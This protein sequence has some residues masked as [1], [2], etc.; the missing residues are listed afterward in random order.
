MAFI[1]VAVNWATETLQRMKF[2]ATTDAIHQV[3]CARTLGDVAA[4]GRGGETLPLSCRA[5]AKCSY[6]ALAL[7]ATH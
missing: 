4:E 7:A 1:A 6:V 5:G 3:R 2:Q